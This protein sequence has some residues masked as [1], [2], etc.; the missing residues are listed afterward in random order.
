MAAPDL[1]VAH[2]ARLARI[3]LT[4]EEASLFQAQLARVLEHIARLQEVAIEGVEPSAHVFPVFNVLRED[5]PQ[6]CLTTAEAL[7]NA[8]RVANDLFIVP[9]VME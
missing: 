3:A 2:V 4:P 8:P 7:R 9:K 6:P 5:E 1:D